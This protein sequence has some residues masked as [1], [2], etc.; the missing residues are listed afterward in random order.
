MHH[1]SFRSILLASFLLTAA[2]FLAFGAIAARRGLESTAQ[3][4]KSFY[5]SRGL[6]EGTETILGFVAMLVWPAYFAPIAWVFAAL[7]VLTAALRVAAA[8]RA[9]SPGG[10]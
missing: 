10:P 4:R 1:L 9:F 6:V 2:S 5:Y 8:W 3:G 7:C